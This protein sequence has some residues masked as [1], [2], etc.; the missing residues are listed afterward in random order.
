[1]LENN[2]QDC[3]ILQGVLTKLN[4][5]AEP[6]SLMCHSCHPHQAV[7]RE[8]GIGFICGDEFRIAKCFVVM[9]IHPVKGSRQ[10]ETPG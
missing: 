2:F 4:Y 6:L 5:A 1:M 3:R 8:V 7:F 10:N 9:S